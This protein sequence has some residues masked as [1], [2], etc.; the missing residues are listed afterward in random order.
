MS[1]L[2]R[3]VARISSARSSA[4]YKVPPFVVVLRPRSYLGLADDGAG[5]LHG[6]LARTLHRA[7]ERLQQSAHVAARDEVG[8]RGVEFVLTDELAGARLRVAR[9]TG[10]TS[11]PGRSGRAGLPCG[12][13]GAGGPVS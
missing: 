4:M 11:R 3:S 2:M 7:A 10:R 9:G 6:G 1:R 8:D 12:A 13:R 5:V